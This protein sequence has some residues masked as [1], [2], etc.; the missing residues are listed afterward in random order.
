MIIK[1]RDTTTFMSS[2][3][4]SF[5][6]KFAFKNQICSTH[7]LHLLIIN[8]TPILELLFLSTL[9]NIEDSQTCVCL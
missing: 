5:L 2:T 4:I 1:C 7:F 9:L 3:W 6:N 8:Q